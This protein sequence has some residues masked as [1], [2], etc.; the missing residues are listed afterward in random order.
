MIFGVKFGGKKISN[1]NFQGGMQGL[2]IILAFLI[3]AYAPL[4]PSADR[5]R[6]DEGLY[7]D[8]AIRMVQTGDYITPYYHD[9]SIRL[10]K[11]ILTYWALV[12]SYKIFGISLWSSRIPFLVAGCLIVWF[13]YNISFSLFRSKEIALIAAALIASNLTLFHISIRSTPDA[14][15]CLFISM[16]LYGFSRLIF[17]RERKLVDYLLAYTGA[18][19]AAATKGGWGFLPIT[20]VFLCAIAFYRDRAPLRTLIEWKGIAIFIF[21]ASFWYVLAYYQNGDVFIRQFWGDQ[22]GERISR[23]KW[24][25]IENILVYVSAIIWGFMPWPLIFLPIMFGRGT[26]DKIKDLFRN[27]RGPLLFALGWYLFLC[28]TFSFGNI[29]RTR[30]LFPAYPLVSALYAAICI[31]VAKDNGTVWS[32][33]HQIPR[34]LL[35]AC[36]FWGLCSFAAGIFI[37]RILILGGITAVVVAAAISAAPFHDGHRSFVL[38]ISLYIILIFSLTANFICRVV[39]DSPAFKAVKIVRQ[40]REGPVEIAAINIHG[41]YRAQINVLSGGLIRVQMY[42]EA[43]NAKSLEGFPFIIISEGALHEMKDFPLDAYEVRECGYTYDRER[44]KISSLR[45][46]RTFDDARRLLVHWQKR[47]YLLIKRGLRF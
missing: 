25:V 16:S 31:Y 17:D 29:Q 18:G 14:L 45:V 37:D 32:V 2:I 3:L 33:I 13:T 34:L 24:Y 5:Y 36:I 47:Y 1:N 15:L 39:Y 23:S 9:G 28:L 7:T 19:L 38:K 11:P 8:A 22:L 35:W 27:N 41:H 21:I 42:S 46:I 30:F 4:L 10:R 6:G 43:A 12:T 26:S 40:Y 44:F 20:Y